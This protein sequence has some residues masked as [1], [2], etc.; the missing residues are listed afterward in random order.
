VPVYKKLQSA[1]ARKSTLDEQ[2][3][4]QG[5]DMSALRRAVDKQPMQSEQQVAQQQ[6]AQQQVAQQQVALQQVAQQELALQQV[7]QYVEDVQ[8]PVA[9]QQV[10]QASEG[11][12]VSSFLQKYITGDEDNLENKWNEMQKELSRQWQALQLIE[13]Q[14]QELAEKEKQ[15]KERAER[16]KKEREEWEKTRKEQ[17]EK[18]KKEQAEKQLLL[19]CCIDTYLPVKTQVKSLTSKNQDPFVTHAGLVENVAESP[20]RI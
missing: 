2:Q 14:K 4:A 15:K 20:M 8:Q 6:V 1:S 19:N 18:H 17:A 7:A 11:M 9:L 10:V 3:H 16:L 13:K 5:A 12:E